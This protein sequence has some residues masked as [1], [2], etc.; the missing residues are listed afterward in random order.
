MDSPDNITLQRKQFFIESVARFCDKCG[1]PYTVDDLN[2]VQNTGAST[3]IHFS[4]H[5]CKAKHIAT[6]V[7][8]LGVTQRVPLNT[9]LA[10]NEL[11]SFLQYRTITDQEIL[12]VY[13]ELKTE[14]I[15][16]F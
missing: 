10:E 12:D 16:K 15:A 6:L 8:P 13:N 2:I 11:Q 5:N 3:I 9:D 4:C 14:K 7:S 1:T